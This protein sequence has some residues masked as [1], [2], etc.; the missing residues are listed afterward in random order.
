MPAHIVLVPSGYSISIW[1]NQECPKLTWWHTMKNLRDM[2]GYPF[3]SGT[4]HVGSMHIIPFM[5]FVG[6]VF[7]PLNARMALELISV[8]SFILPSTV[9]YWMFTMCKA[10][11]E[12]LG[13]SGSLK[14]TAVILPSCFAFLGSGL[15]CIGPRESLSYLIVFCPNWE[16]LT[17]ACCFSAR[18]RLSWPSWRITLL[19][20]TSFTCA[21]MVSAGDIRLKPHDWKWGDCGS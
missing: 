10:L 7:S 1:V 13:T 16:R 4:C 2:E 19:F 18:W 14:K 12:K 8:H 9:P 15:S 20:G 6:M 3:P 21:L 11:S 17:T 5:G